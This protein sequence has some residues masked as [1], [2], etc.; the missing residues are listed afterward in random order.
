M[1]SCLFIFIELVYFLL[2][3]GYAGDSVCFYHRYIR[4]DRVVLRVI[5]LR[6]VAVPSSK[7]CL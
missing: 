1:E 4:E 3:V 5:I 6:T 7:D 2:I